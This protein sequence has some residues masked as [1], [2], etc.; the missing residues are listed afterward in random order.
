MAENRGGAAKKAAEKPANK[1]GGEVKP[2]QDGKATTPDENVQKSSAT[3]LQ[4]ESDAPTVESGTTSAQ[5]GTW[6]QTDHLPHDKSTGHVVNS[7]P[8]TGVPAPPDVTPDRYPSTVLAPS[9]S[10]PIEPPP[11]FRTQG[12]PEGGYSL[13]ST[14]HVWAEAGGRTIAGED[15]VG[16]VGDDG[17]KVDAKSLFDEGDG[18]KTTVTAKETVW[19]EFVYPN[20]VVVSKRRLFSKGAVVPRA[21][22]ARLLAAVEAAPE[23]ADADLIR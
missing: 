7:G 16:L 17:N 20:T 22:A 21:Q 19:E 8:E 9:E 14:D 15:F 1:A 13:S 12:V 23:P 5:A 6:P 2:D 11:D 3:S 18:T 4:G 10:G